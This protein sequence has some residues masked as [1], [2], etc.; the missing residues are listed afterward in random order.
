MGCPGHSVLAA[1]FC[2]TPTGFIHC[3]YLPTCG[4][5]VSLPPSPSVFLGDTSLFS[6]PLSEPWNRWPVSVYCHSDI[7]STNTRVCSVAFLLPPTWPEQ[8]KTPR[9]CLLSGWMNKKEAK[10]ICKGQA[11]S[12]VTQVSSPASRLVSATQQVKA[13]AWSYL[14]MPVR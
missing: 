2:I 5:S 1:P 12:R 7:S 11:V 10:E 14:W 3:Y 9:K 6:C 13:P 8:E 4:K